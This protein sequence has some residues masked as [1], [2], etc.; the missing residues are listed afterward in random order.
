M[1][2]LSR[3][4]GRL[5]M[6]LC[7]IVLGILLFVDPL[8]FTGTIIKAGGILL[9]IAGLLSAIRYFRADPVEAHLEQGLARAL[10]ELAGGAFC[11]F[12]T[13]WFLV[14]FPIITILY[15]VVILFTG[16]LRVQWTV[17]ML[18]MKTGR[19]YLPGAGALFSLAFGVVIIRNPFA[20]TGLLWMFV[21]I[22]MIVNAVFDLCSV[23]LGSLAE[24]K[25]ETE[26]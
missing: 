16:I 25:P 12:K 22:S 1:K 19:W 18:R 21:A 23:F 10:C 2:N 7:E 4:S 3:Y 13:E 20:S 11:V 15:G 6:S 14:T 9:M 5:I 24:E 17:D 26:E 8:G